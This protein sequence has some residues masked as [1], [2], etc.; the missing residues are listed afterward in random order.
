MFYL[1]SSGSGDGLW[2]FQDGS[3]SWHLMKIGPT[4]FGISKASDAQSL[5]YRFTTTS[6]LLYGGVPTFP[7]TDVNPRGRPDFYTTITGYTPPNAGVPYGA[8]LDAQLGAFTDLRFPWNS[9][10]AWNALDIPVVGPC[11]IALFASVKQTNPS[12]RGVLSPAPTDLG[13]LT[14]ESRFL[15]AYPNTIYWRVGGS[16]ILE[17]M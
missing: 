5:N 4:G 13:A 8:P 2:R 12:S 11:Y 16:L 6:A 15:L 17:D 3:V 1:S 10:Q 9:N 14:P 7:A